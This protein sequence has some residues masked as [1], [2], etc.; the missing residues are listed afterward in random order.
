MC[1]MHIEV[2]MIWVWLTYQQYYKMDDTYSSTLW[3]LN[4]VSTSIFHIAAEKE[5]D[6][7]QK[8]LYCHI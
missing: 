2:H 3:F 8:S 6:T 1:R 7:T 4:A 5:K